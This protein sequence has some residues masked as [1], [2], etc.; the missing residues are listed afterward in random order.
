MTTEQVTLFFAQLAIVAEFTVLVFALLVI[1]GLF[2]PAI[3]RA[4][5]L[6]VQTIA[7]AALGLAFAVACVSMAGSLYFSE[8]A[9]F[10]PCK[11]CWY[12]RIAMYPLVPVLGI[13]AIRRDTNVRI[14]GIALAGIGA[15]ISSY[16]VLLE[17]F[18]SLESGVC[19][20]NN[21]CTLIW[22]ERFD[23]LTIPTMALSGFA[24]IVVLLLVAGRHESSRVSAPRGKESTWQ[25]TRQ[26]RNGA[27]PV[28]THA[29]GSSTSEREQSGSGVASSRS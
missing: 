23:Y 9:H 29:A 12:Q 22:V 4:R 20:P 7:P 24:A 14:Y 21:P 25:S 28:T 11:L 16:H 10:V 3:A 8:V 13:A 1:G 27:T 2:S 19:D 5:T 6:A 26:P 18:P 15:L 17:R